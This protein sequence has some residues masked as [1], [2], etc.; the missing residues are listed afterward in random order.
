MARR[1]F[2]V[3]L[4]VLLAVM[5]LSLLIPCTAFAVE[6]TADIFKL[7][8]SANMALVVEYEG[9][10]PTIKII[11]PN[12]R[13]LEADDFTVQSG[14]KSITY[15]IPD[16]AR[17]QW[18]IRYDKKGSDKLNVSWAPYAEALE[19]TSLRYDRITSSDSDTDVKFT[20]KSSSDDRYSYII[21]AAVTDE[22]G[23]VTG[24]KRL[25]DGSARPGEECTKNVG[26]RDLQPYHSYYIYLEVWR[27]DNGIEVSDSRL[28]DNTFKID[29][30]NMPEPMQNFRVSVDMSAAALELN[31]QDYSK[32]CDEY[33]VT[34]YNADDTSSP[35]YNMSLD[36][37][38]QT[39]SVAY[40][41]DAV[42]LIAEI[43][44]ID[45]NTA[46]KTL[47]KTI[48]VSSV[49]ITMP[50]EALTSSQQ[51][52]I[53]YDAAQPVAAK[54]RLNGS[55]MPQQLNLSGSG[56]FSVSLQEFGNDIA[57]FYSLDDDHV[58]YSYNKQITVDT[59]APMLSLPENDVTLYTSDKTFEIAGS[60]E[61]GSTV[62]INGTP[63]EVMADGIFVYIASINLG[64]NEFIVKATDEAGNTSSQL[65]L[66]NGVAAGTANIEDN[67]NTV[68]FWKKYL[69]LA[70]TAVAGIIVLISAFALTKAYSGYIA[71]S[72]M[73][74]VM[75]EIRNV[76]AI[77]LAVSVVVSGA[78]V[79][80]TLKSAGDVNS[81]KIFET[82]D[83]SLT[84]AYDV[85]VN[86]NNAASAM[87]IS[88]FATAGL[89]LL[90]AAVLIA[91]RI[92]K[93]RAAEPPKP[94]KPKK[95]KPPKKQRNTAAPSAD[96]PVMKAPSAASSDET[97]LADTTAAQTP[98]AQTSS[99]DTTAKA[100]FCSE[101]G[102]RNEA[103]SMFCDKCGSRL[104]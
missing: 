43:C 19:I 14:N 45:G 24:K 39:A 3:R 5:L 4:I 53:G 41:T 17:G 28:S 87:K 49:R 83:K 79:F 57:V 88:L 32:R 76:A 36:S 104:G 47:S 68:P 91:S 37:N 6:V 61:I 89:A 38:V 34:V 72:K 11:R 99:T 46:S 81:E 7:D 25:A 51:I 63:V 70:L 59:T 67:T 73:Y 50:T 93:K 21:Y 90:F 95:Q 20:V 69:P 60:A 84:Q 75:A 78:L 65:F 101:C 77:L 2:S 48:P 8:S 80:V 64:E 66:I 102:A 16:C 13:E 82:A 35:I 26:L 55:D 31:W 54:V 100:V 56:S 92:L 97:L 18:Q 74:A 12:G 98:S 94:S 15:F 103:G 30:D 85:I 22:N 29:G 40:P 71:V 42:S 62:T 96:I 23:N 52:S 10:L 9:S 27:E 58:V 44:Y 33:I 86:Y 1:R